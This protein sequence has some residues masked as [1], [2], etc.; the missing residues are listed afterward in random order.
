MKYS[1]IKAITLSGNEP[2]IDV[3]GNTIARLTDFWRWAY[4]NLMGNTERGILAEYIVACALGIQN[5][6]RI[7]WDKYDLLMNTGNKE[8]AIEVKSSGYLQSWGQTKL[9]EL[10]FGIQPT[11]AWEH[12]SNTY[13]K[14]KVRQSHI[15]VFCVHKHTEQKNLNPLNISQWDFYL[16]PTEILNQKVGNRKSIVLSSLIKIGAEKCEYNN[17]KSRIIE[18]VRIDEI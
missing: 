12:F 7:L 16:L 17:L 8:I 1:A 3:K 11:L 14:A 5:S 13:E 2:I 10:R 9:S 15:Y 6:E 18:L 4:S